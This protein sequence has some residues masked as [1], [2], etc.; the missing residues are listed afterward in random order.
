MIM[1]GKEEKEHDENF[2]NFMEKCISKTSLLMW[3]RFSSSNLR[4]LS[5]AIAAQKKE[6]YPKK[7]EALTYMK[8]PEDKETMRS[9]HG[10]INHLKKYSALSSHLS[11]LLSALTHQHA[12]YKPTEEHIKKFKQLKMEASMMG[13]LPYFDVNSETTLQTN[14]SKS[15]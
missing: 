15:A 12:D 3:R 14:T 9:F 6:L 5:L 13:A 11:A 10:M 4:Y 7:I 1:Y 8:F 2:L